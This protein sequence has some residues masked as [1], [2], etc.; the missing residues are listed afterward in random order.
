MSNEVYFNEP[1]FENEAGTKD[2]ERKNE[3]YANIVRYGNVKWAMLGQLKNPS[4]GFE[5]V[6]KRHFYVKKAEILKD[7]HKWIDRAGKVEALY[8]GLTHDHNSNIAKD[9]Q[10]SKTR[11]KEALEKEVMEFEEELN[12]MD[13]PT[14]Y[15]PPVNKREQ[16]KKKDKKKDQAITEGQVSIDDVDVADDSVQ[17]DTSSKPKDINVEDDAVKDR[18]SRY[19][20]AMGVEAVAKQAAANIFVSGAGALGVEISKNLVLSGCKSFTLHDTQ[21][22]TQRDLSGQFFLNLAEGKSRSEICLPRL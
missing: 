12:K 14:N 18:W 17:I 15:L 8:T 19:I 10:K 2:G 22:I 4:K 7:L 20:G 16:R 9:F 13:K 5:T 6:I 21:P 11:Y 1:G 3:G